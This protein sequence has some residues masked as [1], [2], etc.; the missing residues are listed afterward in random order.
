VEWRKF[1]AV[2][3][4]RGR[5]TSAEDAAL[6]QL[7]KFSTYHVKNEDSPPGKLPPYNPNSETAQPGDIFVRAGPPLTIPHGGNYWGVTEIG[8]VHY[9]AIELR[10][11]SKGETYVVPMHWTT[12]PGPHLNFYRP[13]ESEIPCIYTGRATTLKNLPSGRAGKLSVSGICGT[14]MGKRTILDNE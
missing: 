11:D 13:L 6:R 7:A 14:G 9:D 10:K 2:D 1:S 8:D 12:D 3:L 4:A 5:F